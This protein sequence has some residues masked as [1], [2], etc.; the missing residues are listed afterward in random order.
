MVKLR[1]TFDTMSKRTS[2]CPLIESARTRVYHPYPSPVKVT[3][4]GPWYPVLELWKQFKGGQYVCG[5]L[6]IAS[7]NRRLRTL[8]GTYATHVTTGDVCPFWRCWSLSTVRFGVVSEVL[9]GVSVL[10]EISGDGRDLRDVR[11]GRFDPFKSTDR[12]LRRT[13]GG[14]APRRA[15][16]A[17]T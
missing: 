9:S 17:R 1:S 12:T 2:P 5:Y 6:D 10:D 8:P 13:Y 14:R 15:A 4:A 16:P 7:T 3:M 11:Y